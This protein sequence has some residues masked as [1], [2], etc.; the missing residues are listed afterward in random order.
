[1]GP[2]K[3]KASAYPSTAILLALLYTSHGE[4]QRAL[5]LLHKPQP[6][7]SEGAAAE[8]RFA[9][10]AALRN[11]VSVIISLHIALNTTEVCEAGRP[12][13]AGVQLHA[14]RSQI[15][16][17][18][19]ALAVLADLLP[20]EGDLGGASSKGMK[21]HERRDAVTTLGCVYS[22]FL[23]FYGDHFLPEEFWVS[24]TW[25]ERCA[26]T[27]EPSGTHSPGTRSPAPAGGTS[28]LSPNTRDT[29]PAVELGFL[30][31]EATTHFI[32]NELENITAELNN[33]L[34]ADLLYVECSL[35]LSSGRV[36]QSASSALKGG[37]SPYDVVADQPVAE[38]YSPTTPSPNTEGFTKTG[39]FGVNV[40]DVAR[41]SHEITAHQAVI[42]AALEK[43]QTIVATDPNYYRA[44]VRMGALHL[45]GGK[46]LIIGPD[47]SAQGTADVDVIAARN[48]YMK[49]LQLLPTN[50]EAVQGLAEVCQRAGD[51]EAACQYLLSGAELELRA[52]PV[53]PYEDLLP[54]L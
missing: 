4:Y 45:R 30:L 10:F 1:M 9:I 28:S 37:K 38:L 17:V 23:R 26:L 20:P 53:I 14:A 27:S 31:V 3:G 54:L 19:S 40:T 48:C 21:P 36:A 47:G 49:A 16:K 33:T 2:T 29:H 50:L 39:L 51:H 32:T 25:G 12:A 5:Q 13:L 24:S 8:L 7:S 41:G 46:E 43:L 6:K 11:V 52:N 42:K 44:Y 22:I 15:G 18:A 35:L 34:M